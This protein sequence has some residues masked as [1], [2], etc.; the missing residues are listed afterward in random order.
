M[1]ETTDVTTEE[2]H[3]VL[4]ELDK[5][6]DAVER[7]LQFYNVSSDRTVPAI[8]SIVKDVFTHYGDSILNKLIMQIYNGVSTLSGHKYLLLVTFILICALTVHIILL[9][10]N[11]LFN[12]GTI[13]Q[14]R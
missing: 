6:D 14:C 9:P 5:K 7:F 8:I 10:I 13:F 1:D 12:W 4:I 11:C 3:S 2:Q